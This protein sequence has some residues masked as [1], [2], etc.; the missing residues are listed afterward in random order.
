MADLLHAVHGIPN[1]CQI[2]TNVITGGLPGI[3]IRHYDVG[4][5]SV[6]SEGLACAVSAAAGSRSASHLCGIRLACSVSSSGMPS[7][8]A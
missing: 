2:L 4:E 1:A 8:N 3:F 7:C 5:L 6:M